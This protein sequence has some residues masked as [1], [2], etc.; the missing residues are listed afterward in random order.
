M[1]TF[2]TK[3]ADRLQHLEARLLVF[4]L[5]PLKQTLVEQRSDA[6]ENLGWLIIKLGIDSFHSFK[7]AAAIEDAQ[8]LEKYL[9]LDCEQVIAPLDGSAQRLMALGCVTAAHRQHL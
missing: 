6:V 9:L 2:Q 1:Q 8:A 4:L 3:L 7:R 5:P